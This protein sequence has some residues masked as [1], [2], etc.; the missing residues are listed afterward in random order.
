MQ[1]HPIDGYLLDG[2]PAKGD[3]IAAVLAQRSSDERAAPFYRALEAVGTRADDAAL[4][5]LRLVLAGKPPSDDLVRSLR[6][7]VARVRAGDAAARAEYLS[8]VGAS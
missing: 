5:A 7:L 3:A 8:E 4:V 2:K 6:A 1:F